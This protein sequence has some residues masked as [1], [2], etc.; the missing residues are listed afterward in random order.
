MSPY[1]LSAFL[2]PLFFVAC[3]TPGPRVLE[4]TSRTRL[5]DVETTDR[6]YFID[7]RASLIRYEPRDL[8]IDDQREEFYV[9]WTPRTVG[10]V[11]FEYRQVAR[12]AEVFAQTY[13]PH[14]DTRKLFEVRGEAFRSGGLVS[15]WRV[16]LWKGDQLL[17]ETKSMLW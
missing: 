10:L 9:R 3:S 1:K 4:V 15:A 12:P 16:S 5:Q 2:L 7:D 8:S 6:Q 14:G 11:K 13:T 17:A